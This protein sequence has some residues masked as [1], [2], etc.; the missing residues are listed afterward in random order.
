MKPTKQITPKI[1]A[2]INLTPGNSGVDFDLPAYRTETSDGQPCFVS[3]WKMTWKERL[4]ALFAG[5]VW[6]GVLGSGHPPVW[7]AV[8]VPFPEG[9]AQS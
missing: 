5:R 8:T 6:L 4:Q 7:V 9:D 2:N 3:C 1:K